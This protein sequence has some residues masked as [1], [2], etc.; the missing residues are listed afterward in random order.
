MTLRPAAST[1]K[2]R[3][4][5][6]RTSGAGFNCGKSSRE[7]TPNLFRRLAL[8]GA[9]AHTTC[10][11]GRN[12][13]L[14]VSAPGRCARAVPAPGGC[15]LA[16]C[17]APHRKLGPMLTMGH[18]SQSQ[19]LARPT[20][21]EIVRAQSPPAQSRSPRQ[22]S[23]AVTSSTISS[24]LRIAPRMRVNFAGPT[25]AHAVSPGGAQ[26]WSG[27]WRRAC[28]EAGHSSPATCRASEP[29]AVESS[30]L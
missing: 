4:P 8:P 16:V 19:A 24:V 11:A 5:G 18:A 25:C 22:T 2:P 9:G 6:L 27:A 3:A 7:G 15:A 23:R 30:V 20:R 14:A 21:P 29:S 1:S 28:R 12:S 13:S 26:R 17:R 10:A